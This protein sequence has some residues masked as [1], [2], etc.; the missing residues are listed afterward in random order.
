MEASLNGRLERLLSSFLSAHGAASDIAGSSSC[1]MVEAWRTLSGA[2]GDVRLGTSTSTDF[3]VSDVDDQQQ[4]S[5]RL[6]T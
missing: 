4:P 1:F 2:R 6:C 5:V 3:L